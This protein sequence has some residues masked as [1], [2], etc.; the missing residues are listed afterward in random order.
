MAL[1]SAAKRA[2]AITAGGGTFG[3]HLPSSGGI[4][5]AG[6]RAAAAHAYAGIGAGA[7]G[8]A[9]PITDRRR[10]AMIGL[11]FGAPTGGIEITW[12]SRS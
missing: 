11:P 7:G 2:S 8:A 3:M 9:A 5:A 10:R 12:P 6:E 1:D 4:D